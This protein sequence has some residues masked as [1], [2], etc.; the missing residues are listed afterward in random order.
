MLGLATVMGSGRTFYKD[1]FM[2]I[3]I[4]IQGGGHTYEGLHLCFC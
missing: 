4:S 2:Y 1:G 3:I